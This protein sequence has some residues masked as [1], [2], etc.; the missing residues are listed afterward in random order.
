MG[1]TVLPG[2][3]DQTMDIFEGTE[4]IQQGIIGRAISG[5]DALR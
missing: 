4:Q 2:Q 5:H 3:P 1:L